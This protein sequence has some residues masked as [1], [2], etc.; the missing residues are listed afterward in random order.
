M[1]CHHELLL[2]LSGFPGDMFTRR[3]SGKIEVVP[4]LP[5]LHLGEQS[6]LNRICELAGPARTILDFIER[7]E[8]MAGAYMQAFATSLDSVLQRYHRSLLA[9]EK[10]VLKDIKFPVTSI[11][12]RL[13]EWHVILPALVG[14]IQEVEGAKPPG[15]KILDVLAR[16]ISSG[17]PAIRIL[18]TS[19]AA[20]CWEVFVVQLGSWMLHGLVLDRSSDFFV[21]QDTGSEGQPIGK[22]S[23]NR[24][25]IDTQL[26][27]TAVPMRVAEKALFSGKAAIVL[28]NMSKVPGD[29]SAVLS[30]D[31]LARAEHELMVLVS[32]S[33]GSFPIILLE[34]TVEFVRQRMAARLW[35]VVIEQGQLLP[36]LMAFKDFMLAGDG[37]F[38]LELY[39]QGDATFRLPARASAGP[40]MRQIYTRTAAL[41]QC[42][43]SAS[44]QLFRPVVQPVL[45]C[46]PGPDVDTGDLWSLVGLEP[47]LKWPLQ[48]IFNPRVISKY[49][50]FLQFF[51][52]VTRVQLGL[53]Q[54]WVQGQKATGAEKRV[55]V[56]PRVWSLRSRMS[57]VVDNLQY[58]LKIDVLESQFK[59]MLVTVESVRDF[60]SL[61]AAHNEFLSQ[62]MILTF[63][64]GVEIRRVVADIFGLCDSFCSFMHRGGPSREETG[65]RKLEEIEMA[66]DRQ[67]QFL[68][69]ILS[70]ATDKEHLQQLL[71]RINFN[72]HFGRSKMFL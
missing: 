68:F 26:L 27:P 47:N 65:F 61:C 25:S 46:D 63:R 9:L 21:I 55:S 11:Q 43:D 52:R 34:S 8:G 18:F 45:Y 24:F 22:D 51:L 67:S 37:Q 31:E 6:V 12:H 64:N 59:K 14:V 38:F 33:T 5:F 13:E 28:K 41:M 32:E 54:A 57:F 69:Q 1:A 71:L 72:Q 23:W 29:A 62:L 42:E 19:L 44:F 66:F 3:P 36:T 4:G 15:A 20:S 39:H 50:S 70:S 17:V 7:S 30:R 49:N 48:L 56:L 16:R 53:Q 58:Y 60:D 10:E 40:E 35:C 2:A